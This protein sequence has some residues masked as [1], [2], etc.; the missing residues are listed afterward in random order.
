MNCTKCDAKNEDYARYCWNCGTPTDV[1]KTQEH[2]L[3][4]FIS[5]EWMGFTQILPRVL[6]LG[7][8]IA[9]AL[10]L[11]LAIYAAFPHDS[12]PTPTYL[13]VLV[14]N[15]L[16]SGIFY[17]GILIGLAG[18]ISTQN[19]TK[20]LLRRKVLYIAA[21]VLLVLGIILVALNM[22]SNNTDSI[23]DKIYYAL[24]NFLYTGLFEGGVIAG[25]AALNSPW[26]DNK[27][28]NF[29]PIVNI[30]Y[31]AA[32]ITVILAIVLASLFIT[33]V[34]MGTAL[35]NIYL[36]LGFFLGYGILNGGILAALGRLI[37]LRNRKRNA[38][39]STDE[40]LDEDEEDAAMEI[41]ITP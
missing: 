23:A 36:F 7:A 37:A 1:V 32:I 5:S 4:K 12:H 34:G 18:V 19:D 25:L 6:Y 41:P 15:Q 39:D 27:T 22:F 17:A 8:I 33:L 13:T 31:L 29:S 2:N 16:G 30:L 26:T 10:S 35:A 21:G 9:L 14:I 3:F 38:P 28:Q 40:D 11:F 20:Q 24:K